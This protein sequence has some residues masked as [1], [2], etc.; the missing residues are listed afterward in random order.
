MYEDYYMKQSGTGMPVFIGSRNQRGHGIG[1]VLSGL[2]R[3]AA[4]MLKRGLATFGKHALKTGTQILSDVVDGQ[5]LGESAKRRIK[6][7]IKEFIS[8]S[9]FSQQ[10]GNGRKRTHRRKTSK[11]PKKNKRRRYGDIFD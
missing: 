9:S 8:P 3:S 11:K 10:T 1:S 6:Q 5:S 4:P 2:F 7:G